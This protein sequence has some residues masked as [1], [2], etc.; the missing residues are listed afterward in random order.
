MHEPAQTDT[1]QTHEPGQSDTAPMHEPAQSETAPMYGVSRR[2]TSDKQIS[3]IDDKRRDAMKKQQ[4][5]LS[6]DTETAACILQQGIRAYIARKKA[7]FNLAQPMNLPYE[8]LV[9]TKRLQR[10]N[11][12][13]G[14][15]RDAIFLLILCSVLWA[16]RNVQQRFE[17]ERTLQGFMHEITTPEGLGFDGIES[18][19]DFWDYTENG[20]FTAIVD[21]KSDG[22]RIRTYNQLVGTARLETRRVGPASC[23]WLEYGAPEDLL[24]RVTNYSNECYGLQGGANEPFGPWYDTSKFHPSHGSRFIVDLGTDPTFTRLRLADMRR[25]SFLSEQTREI[26]ISMVVYNHAL[27]MLATMRLQISLSI[28]GQ[29]SKAYFV[30]SIN[31]QEY[32]GKQHVWRLVFE[33]VLFLWVIASVTAETRRV[34]RLG[35]RKA[36]SSLYPCV[37]VLRAACLLVCLGLWLSGQRVALEID[38]MTTEFVDLGEQTQIASTYMLFG[39]FTIMLSLLRT[40]EYFESVPKLAAIVRAVSSVAADLGWFFLLFWMFFFTFALVGH[41]IL[42]PSLPEWSKMF[43]VE[44]G[45]ESAINTCFDMMT[46]NY[47]LEGIAVASAGG[48]DIAKSLSGIIFYYTFIL[49]MFF[50]MLNVLLAILMDGYAAVKSAGTSEAQETLNVHMGSLRTDLRGATMLWCDAALALFGRRNRIVRRRLS[51]WEQEDTMQGRDDVTVFWGEERWA[52]ELHRVIERRRRLGRPSRGVRL[53]TFAAELRAE[54]ESLSESKPKSHLESLSNLAKTMTNLHVPGHLAADKTQIFLQVMHRFND[55]LVHP[56]NNTDKNFASETSEEMI[57]RLS[58]AMKINR[59]EMRKLQELVVVAM[60]SLNG[61][62]ETPR[63][64]ATPVAAPVAEFE[65]KK[66]TG[67]DDDVLAPLAKGDAQNND[68]GRV[69]GGGEEEHD[70]NS[71]ENQPPAAAAMQA[72]EA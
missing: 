22:A 66:E 26:S 29:M 62:R 68:G 40:F 18:L 25:S 53:I 52:T 10:R 33:V 41:L 47:M 38:L 67:S 57:K 5:Y 71:P 1:A 4:R 11:A 51:A 30:Q 13:R 48:G 27:L 43:D 58:D 19:D 44:Y 45:G 65:A 64:L 20:F 42:G 8:L 70:Y 50:M 12:L 35:V 60:G 61:D 36:F 46:G 15:L 49:I 9:I 37:D 16:Q 24:W 17:L 28:S 55:K 6:M 23:E 34:T 32:V 14:F 31:V 56:P 63:Q 3:R 69:G 2:Q 59:A 39:S 72:L 7:P 54:Y 21:A